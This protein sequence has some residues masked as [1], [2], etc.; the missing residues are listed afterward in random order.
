MKTERRWTLPFASDV[1]PLVG[2]KRHLSQLDTCFYFSRG[3]KWKDSIWLERGPPNS[4]AIIRDRRLGLRDVRDVSDRPQL[5]SRAPRN[6]DSQGEVVCVFPAILGLG[7][8]KGYLE[9]P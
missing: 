6:P 1:F 8:K 2:S 9:P 5:W 4:G 7:Q 3:L